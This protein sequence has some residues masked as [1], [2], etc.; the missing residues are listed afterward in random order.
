ME[1]MTDGGGGRGWRKDTI[2]SDACDS[3]SLA[4]AAWGG[5]GGEVRGQEAIAVSWAKWEGALGGL[6]SWGIDH[7]WP[8]RPRL[9][10]VS[11]F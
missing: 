6:K 9:P 10:L 4:G 2:C 5:E 11:I 7:L 3:G 8:L 1:G